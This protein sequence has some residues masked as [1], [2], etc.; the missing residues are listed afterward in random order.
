MMRVLKL[1]L[2]KNNPLLESLSLHDLDIS[3][4]SFMHVG[5][6]L[7]QLKSLKVWCCRNLAETSIECILKNNSAMKCLEFSSSFLL[8]RKIFSY[9]G[10]YLTELKKLRI[11]SYLNMQIKDEIIETIILN[12]KGLQHIVF[13]TCP[14][15]TQKT[16]EYISQNL[17]HLK[18]FVLGYNANITN[19]IV[20][21]IVLNNRDIEH[22]VFSDCANVTEELFDF[23]KKIQHVKNIYIYLYLSYNEFRQI[24]PM[25]LLALSENQNMKLKT[26]NKPITYAIYCRST[27]KR[28]LSS[29]LLMV[30]QKY[31][32]FP[33]L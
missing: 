31:K 10:K 22:L 7:H 33:T 14:K 18:S 15:L 27:N 2:F 17:S 25:Q 6:N 13:A 28:L 5:K 24:L 9:I 20:Y 19:K 32:I 4:E 26:I 23:G 3:S 29:S 12:N 1:L 8:S 30:A 11:G 16:F 21:D